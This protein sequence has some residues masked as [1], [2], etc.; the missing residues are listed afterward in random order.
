MSKVAYIHIWLCRTKFTVLWNPDVYWPQF[1]DRNLAL[2]LVGKMGHA[3]CCYCYVIFLYHISWNAPDIYT[4]SIRHLRKSAPCK[5]K[6]LRRHFRTMQAHINT[7]DVCLHGQPKTQLSWTK[8]FG[9]LNC[10]L[11]Y[12]KLKT[13][14]CS[15]SLFVS[16][17]ALWCTQVCIHNSPCVL[18]ITRAKSHVWLCSEW[19]Y[20]SSEAAVRSG[21]MKDTW[22]GWVIASWP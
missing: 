15:L 12:G 5:H 20:E 13:T 3:I 6:L 7:V 19:L 2:S 11:L 10:L 22:A 9:K 8:S 16:A 14:N 4:K 21:A 1:A 17:F 18:L